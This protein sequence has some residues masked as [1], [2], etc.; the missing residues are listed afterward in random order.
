MTFSPDAYWSEFGAYLGHAGHTIELRRRQQH[1]HMRLSPIDAVPISHAHF[2]VAL[3]SMDS[4]VHQAGVRVQLVIEKKRVVDYYHALRA[5]RDYINA[6]IVGLNWVEP[7]GSAARHVRVWKPS[8]PER[9]ELWPEDFAWL[10]GN[11]LLLRRE[12]SPLLQE[13]LERP[14]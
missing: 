9:R 2:A 8:A 6:R 7:P 5:R 3:T 10:A 12:L 4:A 1:P 13:A 11:L 14:H